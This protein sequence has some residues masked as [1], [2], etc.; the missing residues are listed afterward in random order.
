M[1]RRERR[2]RARQQKKLEEKLKRELSRPNP[3]HEEPSAP[4]KRLLQALRKT[5]P[6][7]KLLWSLVGA[8]LAGLSAYALL[9]PHVSVEPYISL[10]PVD[11]YSTQFTVKNESFVSDV[12]NVNCVCWPRRME[13]GNR[14]SV[15]SPGPLPNV[16]HTI[17]VL[18]PGRSGTVDCPSVIGGIGRWAGEVVQ[19]ELEIDISYRQ[20][21]WPSTVNERYP[22]TAMRDSQRGVHWMHITPAEEKE[23]FPR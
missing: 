13:S 12:H 10:N 9:R 16:H 18:Q 21:W 6:G 3:H 19:A 2:R 1:D 20:D 5:L 17:S 14:F 4:P 23:I 7:T 8:V 15:I 22:F 11:P